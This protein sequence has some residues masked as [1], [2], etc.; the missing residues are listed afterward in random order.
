MRLRHAT[1]LH[2]KDLSGNL[3][4]GHILSPKLSDPIWRCDWGRF[5]QMSRIF[6][7]VDE[8]SWSVWLFGIDRRPIGKR[9]WLQMGREFA[10]EDQRR[11]CKAYA[12][13]SRYYQRYGWNL[14][15]SIPRVNSPIQKWPPKR[16]MG[17]FSH[18]RSQRPTWWASKSETIVYYGFVGPHHTLFSF[19]LH[20][21]D[22]SEGSSRNRIA[23]DVSPRTRPLD[24]TR[25]RKP[26]LG[27][28]TGT[29]LMRVIIILKYDD[30]EV[31]RRM[32]SHYAPWSRGQV[33]NMLHR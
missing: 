24:G 25:G 23:G 11:I 5:E 30:Q 28:N 32:V 8:L 16:T 20:S 22:T 6:H 19:V 21:G 29:A 2:R 33:G 13:I 3:T 27:I 1:Y 10:I 18:Q 7:A 17:I 14:N 15:F 12:K 9:L 26:C 4:D 31:H